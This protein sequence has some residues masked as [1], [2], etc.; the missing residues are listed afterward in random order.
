MSKV[1]SNAFDLYI[2]LYL[3][4]EKGVDVANEAADNLI[5]SGE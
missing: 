1:D 2:S 3:A 5:D 4:N